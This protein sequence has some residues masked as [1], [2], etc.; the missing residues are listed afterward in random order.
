MKTDILLSH[1]T[2]RELP[3]DLQEVTA[4]EGLHI[5]K[6]RKDQIEVYSI[7]DDVDVSTDGSINAFAPDQDFEWW[8]GDDV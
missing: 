3:A 7:D 5:L 2:W 6:G 1:D 8:D 4:T